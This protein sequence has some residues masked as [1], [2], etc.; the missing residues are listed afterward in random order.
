M[1]RL[2][3][4]MEHKIKKEKRKENNKEKKPFWTI[5]KVFY[6]IA[7]FIVVAL[8]IIGKDYGMLF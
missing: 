3:E 7:F 6:I 2:G 1:K 5:D 4:N 8:G